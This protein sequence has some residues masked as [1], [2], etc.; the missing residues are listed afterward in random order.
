MAV[1][2]AVAVAAEGEEEGGAA[3]AEGAVGGVVVGV[4]EVEAATVGAGAVERRSAAYCLV[5]IEKLALVFNDF[6]SSVFTRGGSAHVKQQRSKG[7]EGRAE[8][9]E[10]TNARTDRWRPPFCRASPSGRTEHRMTT[11]RATER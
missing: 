11:H 6:K 10:R 1:A 2:V 7:G 9:N 4:V 3:V 5:V 8:A